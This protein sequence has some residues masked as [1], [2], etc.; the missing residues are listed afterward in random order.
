[1]LAYQHFPR[2]KRCGGSNAPIVEGLHI[3]ATLKVDSKWCDPASMAVLAL[4]PKTDKY[5]R[6]VRVH[7]ARPDLRDRRGHHTCCVCGGP[8]RNVLD[9]E[10]WCDKCE[11]YQ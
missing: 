6:V 11:R 8:T 5:D 3:G 4:N 7:L 10:A 9:G 1:M 2:C